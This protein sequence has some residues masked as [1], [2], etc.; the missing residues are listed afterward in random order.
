MSLITCSWQ[1]L[2]LIC[3]QRKQLFVYV[4]IPILVILFAG[5]M[6]KVDPSQIEIPVAIVDDDQSEYS[7]TVIE[8]IVKK[9]GIRVTETNQGEALRLLKTNKIEGVFI[10]KDSFM[11]NILEGRDEEVIDVLKAPHSLG[12]GLISELLSSEVI[13]LSTNVM[14]ADYVLERYKKWGRVENPDQSKEKSPLWKEAWD[15]TDN[16]WEPVPLMS[17]SYQDWG[18][19][20]SG[21]QQSDV[22]NFIRLCGILSFSIMLLSLLSSHWIIEERQNNILARVST[23]SVFLHRYILGHSLTYLGIIF[24]QTI[25]VLIFVGYVYH[26]TIPISVGVMIL[27]LGYLFACWSISVFMATILKTSSQLQVMAIMV[28][29]LTSLFGGSFMHLADVTQRFQQ[30]SYL[31]PQGWLLQGIRNTVATSSSLVVY[32]EMLVFLGIISFFLLVS[33]RRIGGRV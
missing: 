2:K 8:R 14:A 33:L 25:L 3:S 7:R 12:I 29:V 9:P 23:T 19:E 16:Q 30:L 21:I 5:Q 6:M 15:Y 24:I 27:L 22:E 4:L 10:I 17:I 26:V 28:T 32:T 11:Q 18:T 1:R 31:T 13:R 20:T